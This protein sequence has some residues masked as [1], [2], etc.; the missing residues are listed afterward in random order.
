MI[1]L[2]TTAVI[3]VLLL[4]FV[5]LRTRRKRQDQNTVVPAT[6]TAI[7]NDKSI[8]AEKTPELKPETT[9]VITNKPIVATTEK[10]AKNLPQDATLRRHYLTHLHNMVSAVYQANPTDSTLRRHYQTQIAAMMDQCLNN[11]AALKKLMTDYKNLSKSSCCVRKTPL[12]PMMSIS[13]RNNTNQ[14][15]PQDATL[16]RHYVTE[17]RAMLNTLHQPRPSDACLYR[18]YQTE[19]QAQLAACLDD[20][21]AETRLREHYQA[22]TNGR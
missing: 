8:V 16:R 17:L 5:L 18:H 22:Y 10:Q 20:E 3:I 6:E 19:I 15:I 13:H 4:V 7:T 9:P 11:D 1:Y 12:A 2:A 14:N 21:Q